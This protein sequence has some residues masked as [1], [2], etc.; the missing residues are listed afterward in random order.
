M[1]DGS[2]AGA[3]TAH[4]PR[5]ALAAFALSM[6]LLVS[7]GVGPSVGAAALRTAAPN[8]FCQAMIS[9]HPQPPTGTDYASYRAF[10]KKYL[11]YYEKLDARAPNVSVKRLLNQ[12]IAI[13]KVEAAT[14][15]RAKLAAYVSAK[16]V[17][18]YED[19]TLFIKSIAACGS[20]VINLL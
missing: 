6:G 2:R 7:L 13:M 20:W 9:V 17:V 15:N 1:T 12:V 19:W 11:K 4:R 3:M 18:W 14:S 10:A 8:P 16:Q 5:A